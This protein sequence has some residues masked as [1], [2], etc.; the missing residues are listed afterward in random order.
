MVMV[1]DANTKKHRTTIDIE[2]AAKLRVA[3]AAYGP[4]F[5]KYRPLDQPYAGEED[6]VLLTIP[7]DDNEAVA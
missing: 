2:K 6:L 7:G 3:E 4:V 5:V 1:M